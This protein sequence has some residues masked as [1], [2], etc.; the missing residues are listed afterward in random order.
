[1]GVSVVG[2]FAV[3]IDSAIPS[4]GVKMDHSDFSLATM[5]WVSLY[6]FS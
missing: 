4:S 2:V 1:M 6:Y 3:Y 5:T